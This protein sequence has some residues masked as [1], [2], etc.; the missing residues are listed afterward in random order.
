[1]ATTPKK[2]FLYFVNKLTD[3]IQLHRNAIVIIDDSVCHCMACICLPWFQHYG[4]PNQ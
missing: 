3:A 4:A 2:R 1:M